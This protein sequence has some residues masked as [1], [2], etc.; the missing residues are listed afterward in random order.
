MTAPVRE[1][2]ADAYVRAAVGAML[3][4]EPFETLV[5]VC[6]RQA[7]EEAATKVVDLAAERAKRGGG[8]KCP[9][10]HNNEKPIR[11]AE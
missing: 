7:A 9:Q 2:G 3:R 4:G 8:S 10:C 1:P 6:R 5:D 11:A